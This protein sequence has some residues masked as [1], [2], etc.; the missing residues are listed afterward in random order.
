MICFQRI[1][2]RTGVGVGGPLRYMF[3]LTMGL[4]SS[5]GLPN[6]TCSSN[7]NSNGFSPKILIPR[8]SSACWRL[9]LG[10]L[11]TLASTLWC[12][13]FMAAH[14]AQR[15][16][17]RMASANPSGILGRLANIKPWVTQ[18]IA[19]HSVM[20]MAEFTAASKDQSIERRYQ[21]AEA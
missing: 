20:V 16:S 5:W 18:S 14:V 21:N 19:I 15:R 4:R 8:I 7:Q 9:I 12:R 3:A 17:A 11:I 6:A 2:E 13:L 1:S 10:L